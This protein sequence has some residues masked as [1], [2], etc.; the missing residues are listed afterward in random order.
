MAIIKVTLDTEK[1]TAKPTGNAT[2]KIQ[3]RFKTDYDNYI[4]EITPQ[5]LLYAVGKEG[6][7]WKPAIFNG[8]GTGNAHF[9]ELHVLGIDIDDVEHW[10]IQD[11][12]DTLKAYNL[13]YTGIYKT[14]SYQ[15]NKQKHRIIFELPAVVTD[16]RMVTLLYLLFMEILPA[17]K[18]C[19]DSARLF[20]GGNNE[21]IVGT[22][23][24][25]DLDNLY[26]AFC[27]KMD[28]LPANRKSDKLKEI[29]GKC[30]I[31]I[32]NGALDIEVTELDEICK[33]IGYHANALYINKEL[34]QYPKKLHLLFP[35]FQIS[36]LQYKSRGRTAATKYEDVEK[37]YNPISET[38]NYGTEKVD[39]ERLADSCHLLDDVLYGGYW[40]YH[41][42][43]RLLTYNIH[44][45]RGAIKALTNSMIYNSHGDTCYV[46]KIKNL[47]NTAIKNE[48]LPEN[49]SATNCPHYNDCPIIARGVQKFTQLLHWWKIKTCLLYR[50]CME[51]SE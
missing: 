14:F 43:L 20:F 15:E 39:L 34:P 48:Y 37:S 33:K 7:S 1:F 47:V 6:R 8:E 11:T 44:P 2:S 49:C 21:P 28:K 24:P 46:Y 26:Y 51:T 17:D 35:N 25:L 18:A 12:I 13:D 41:N 42:E 32:V 16:K 27:D 19:K 9:K 10:T 23:F 38:L 45:V 3:S 50:G 30:G 4:A 40:A 22:A 31:N 36:D 5:E 29:G